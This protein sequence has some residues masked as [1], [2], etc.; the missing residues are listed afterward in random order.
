M[1]ARIRVFFTRSLA[2]PRKHVL[3]A[4]SCDQSGPVQLNMHLASALQAKAKTG[5][6]PNCKM[7]T[8]SPQVHLSVASSR[9]AH[10]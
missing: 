8:T 3:A 2:K 7:P 6:W 9:A 4:A 1:H 5:Q 10:R